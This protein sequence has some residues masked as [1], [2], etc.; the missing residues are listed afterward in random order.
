MTNQS[1]I[2]RTVD[3]TVDIDLKKLYYFLWN[4]SGVAPLIVD[5]L[6]T[7]DITIKGACTVV[8]WVPVVRYVYTHMF[9]KFSKIS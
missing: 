2:S 5:L 9:F 7:L 3:R 4:E 1:T 8:S 6:G